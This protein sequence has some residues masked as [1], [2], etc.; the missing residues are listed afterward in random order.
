MQSL[1]QLSVSRSRLALVA[2][3][4]FFGAHYSA[5]EAQATDPPVIVYFDSTMLPGGYYLVDGYV[6]HDY[7]EYCYVEYSGVLYGYDAW[8]DADGYFYVCVW[9]PPNVDG[10]IYA[11][12][13]DFLGQSS[14]W[15]LTYI[16]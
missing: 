4:L 11:Q 3:A 7:P 6:I 1:W 2:V 8:P 13:T 12:A 16:Q 10:D 15:V 14:S 5:S 9:F